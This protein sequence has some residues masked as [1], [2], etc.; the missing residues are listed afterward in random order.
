MESCPLVLYPQQV[1]SLASLVPPGQLTSPI[2]RAAHRLVASRCRLLQLPHSLRW[3]SL[4]AHLL[5]HVEHHRDGLPARI[6]IPRQ[7]I[8]TSP[9]PRWLPAQTIRFTS[10]LLLAPSP[11]PP[12]RRLWFR[13]PGEHCHR[14]CSRLYLPL[15]IPTGRPP[16]HFLCRFCHHLAYKSELTRPN[17]KISAAARSPLPPTSLDLLPALPLW[18]RWHTDGKGGKRYWKGVEWVGG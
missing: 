3:P 14:R 8:L 15:S 9:T 17:E 4:G 1:L 7:P 6:L 11:G 5:L 16:T 18:L 12:H 2:N 10:D 13:C